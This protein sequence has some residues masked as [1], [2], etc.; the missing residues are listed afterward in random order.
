MNQVG[1]V[2]EQVHQFTLTQ[3][4]NAL[5]N[6]A[7]NYSIDLPATSTIAAIRDLYD[8]GVLTDS[9]EEELAKRLFIAVVNSGLESSNAPLIAEIAANATNYLQSPFFKNY[10]RDRLADIQEII[11]LL[12]TETFSAGLAPSDLAGQF[13]MM[14]SVTGNGR[15]RMKKHGCRPYG[16]RPFRFNPPS[17]THVWACGGAND[18]NIVICGD[19]TNGCRKCKGG[20]GAVCERCCDYFSG[21]PLCKRNCGDS[22]IAIADDPA[23]IPSVAGPKP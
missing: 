11:L 21:G 16:Y 15:V 5:L 2:Y 9:E 7:N 17:P 1:T 22:S 13:T 10:T 3:D 14:P 23:S 18:T 19:P 4:L 6:F 12:V 20:D 8:F